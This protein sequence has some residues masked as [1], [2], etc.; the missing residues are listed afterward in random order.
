MPKLLIRRLGVV[1]VEVAHQAAAATLVATGALQPLVLSAAHH[2]MRTM[3]R[4]ISL[5]LIAILTIRQ[6]DRDQVARDKIVVRVIVDL[7]KVANEEKTADPAADTMT[8]VGSASLVSLVRADL[9]VMVHGG[10]NARG[11]KNLDMAMIGEV[12]DHT[13]EQAVAPALRRETMAR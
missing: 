7:V 13:E 1:V 6:L 10:T 12:E 11:E 2:E 4:T 9:N 8:A 5:A 3:V